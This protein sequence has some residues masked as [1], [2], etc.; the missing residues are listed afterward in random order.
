MTGN[1]LGKSTLPNRYIRLKAN[2]ACVASDDIQQMLQSE[3]EITEKIEAEYKEALVKKWA[4][5]AKHM[6]DAGAQNYP[7]RTISILPVCNYY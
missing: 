3:A 1:K 5:V 7:V 6:E 2:L 4:R